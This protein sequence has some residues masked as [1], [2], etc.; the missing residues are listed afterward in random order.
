MT[1][2]PNSAHEDFRANGLMGGQLKRGTAKN[3]YYYKN[4]GED[5]GSVSAVVPSG[6][7]VEKIAKSELHKG[8]NGDWQKEGYNLEYLN[9]EESGLDEHLV[10][11]MLDGKR[12]GYATYVH[13]NPTTIHATDLKVHPNHQRKGLGRSM[14]SFAEQVTKAKLMPSKIQTE[15]GQKLWAQPNRPFGK[16][17][18]DSLFENLMKNETHSLCALFLFEGCDLPDVLHVTHHYFKDFHDDKKV[19]KVLKDYFKEHPFKPIHTVFDKEAW[20]GDEKDKRVLLPKSK[21]DLLLDLQS[22]LH[23]I[24][25]DKWPTYAP[26]VSVSDNV[27]KIDAPIVK[28]MLIRGNKVLFETE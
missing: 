5:A 1:N 19:I 3:G 24:C 2:T 11:A 21:K 13:D 14:H 8:Q 7:H 20:F 25:P 15:D 12:V 6:A 17:L 22:K 23:E 9:P 28:Y 10:S 26:H 18:T 4:V 16:S 27:D